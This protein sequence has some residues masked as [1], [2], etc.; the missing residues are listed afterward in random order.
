[1][2]AAG[3]KAL[4]SAASTSIS[5]TSSACAPG[6]TPA[7][8]KCVRG[9]SRTSATEAH[10][11]G[12]GSQKT[13]SGSTSISP[14]I[15]GAD[16]TQPRTLAPATISR[17]ARRAGATCT[18]ASRNAVSVSLIMLG[19]VCLPVG[20]LHN[21]CTQLKTPTMSLALVV[22][23]VSRVALMVAWE[24]PYSSHRSII[25]SLQTFQVV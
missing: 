25:S 21:A 7:P 1:M 15:D 24:M 3:S 18:P 16:A 11:V 9:T 12:R 19:L 8:P 23:P 17:C 2:A 14:Q 20:S 4:F 5:G 22:G 13:S 6:S 10:S